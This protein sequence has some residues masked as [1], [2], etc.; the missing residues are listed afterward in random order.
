MHNGFIMT[1]SPLHLYSGHCALD[2]GLSSS[3]RPLDAALLVDVDKEVI[4]KRLLPL[5]VCAATA[6]FTSV[7]TLTLLALNFCGQKCT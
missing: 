4:I 2:S 6:E 7:P 5:V 1:A 3:R